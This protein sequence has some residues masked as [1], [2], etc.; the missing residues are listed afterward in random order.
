MF[1]HG[2]SCLIVIYF[3]GSQLT[4]RISKVE[5]ILSKCKFSPTDF[6]FIRQLMT[7]NDLY[8]I[9]SRC[10]MIHCHDTNRYPNFQ[11]GKVPLVAKVTSNETKINGIRACS[12]FLQLI[13]IY[14]LK[15]FHS[16]TSIVQ[17]I[18]IVYHLYF[19]FNSLSLSNYYN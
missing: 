19:C 18:W 1:C 11:K 2:T 12:S 10:I 5:T 4:V 13:H 9:C 3:R 6:L 15:T 16:K 8:A 7:E 14:L 17:F